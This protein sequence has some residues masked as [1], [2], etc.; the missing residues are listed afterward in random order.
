MD[1]VCTNC[2]GPNDS[3]FDRCQECRTF[4]NRDKNYEKTA[5][6]SKKYYQCRRNNGEVKRYTP[7]PGA[8]AHSSRIRRAREKLAGVFPKDEWKA[9][10]NKLGN[11]CAK[12]GSVGD[13]TIDHIVALS[14]GGTNNIDNLQ[15][16]C[17]QCNCNK[18]T[19]DDKY[20]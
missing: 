15:P 7:L 2:Y 16:L 8:K 6:N 9:L 12:C 19:R 13:I 3:R 5:L 1:K 18:F 10:C 14:K 11:R 4:L 17:M 20:I